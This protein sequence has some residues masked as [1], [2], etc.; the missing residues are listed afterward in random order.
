[1]VEDTGWRAMLEIK[2]NQSIK[3]LKLMVKVF[4]TADHVGRSLFKLED[5]YIAGL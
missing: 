5:M 1:M 4:Q 3:M 2:A